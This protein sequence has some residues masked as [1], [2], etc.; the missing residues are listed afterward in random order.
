MTVVRHRDGPLD[1]TRPCLLYG[2][3]AYEYV[4]EPEFDPALTVLLDRGVAFAHAHVRGGGERGRGWWED[5]R[6]SA[7]QHSFDD[8]MAA[9]RGLGKGLV[10]PGRI[11]ARGLSAGGLVMGASFSQAPELWAGVVAEVPFVDVV[12]SML[13]DTVPLTSTSGTSGVTPPRRTSSAGCWPTRRTTTSPRPVS[14]HR[15]W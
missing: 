1:G 8:H 9:A 10:D 13:D 2:Y 4:F 5:G 11:V 7:K 15:C 14:A 6:L 3:G 12:T